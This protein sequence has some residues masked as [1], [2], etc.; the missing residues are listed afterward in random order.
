MARK[1][2]K[3]KLLES[4]LDL[5][6]TKGYS[7]TTVDELCEAA[8][9]SKGSFYHFFESKE[10]LGLAL[11][12]GYYERS[13][14][15]FLAGAFQAE[16][17]PLKRLF[18]FLDQTEANAAELW[19]DGCLLGNFA[20]DLSNTHPVIRKEV[21]RILD[22]VTESVAELLHP[23]QEACPEREECQPRRLAEL[24]I[25]VIEG[26]IVLSRAHDDWSYLDRGLKGFRHY[27]E[28]VMA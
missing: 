23:A 10:Q 5:M 13:K 4:S 6:L 12:E 27:L 15:K 1:D 19:R 26:A 9:V 8:G 28:T 17:D 14:A 11:L 7:S 25:A 20:V 3:T 16:L 21:A 22:R 24:Y 18:A 2:A